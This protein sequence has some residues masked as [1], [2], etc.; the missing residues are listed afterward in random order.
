MSIGRGE[1]YGGGYPWEKSYDCGSVSSLSRKQCFTKGRR[2]VSDVHLNIRSE[3]SRT[4]AKIPTT[5]RICFIFRC[6]YKRC[7]PQHK[8]NL[9][10]CTIRHNDVLVFFFF[11]TFDSNG[12]FRFYSCH[13][14]IATRLFS[15]LINRQ[16]VLKRT[17]KLFK[18]NYFLIFIDL[19][20]L[21]KKKN[22][23]LKSSKQL[24]FIIINV[25]SK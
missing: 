1:R 20:K 24:I 16:V 14:I 18:Q 25:T 2:H 15:Q 22:Y 19:F 21:D 11:N 6:V 7:V 3:G 4:A 12:Y 23:L 9:H 10:T 5:R 17:K 13:C 8:S